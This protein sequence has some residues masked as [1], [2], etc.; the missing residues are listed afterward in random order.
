MELRFEQQ[1]VDLASGQHRDQRCSWLELW[2]P[3][4]RGVCRVVFSLLDACAFAVQSTTTTPGA[5]SY[6]GFAFDS[7]NN[8][9]W[10]F[11]GSGYSGGNV[12]CLLLLFADVVNACHRAFALQLHPVILSFLSVSVE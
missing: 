1:A 3:R 8:R 6:H 2:Q 5:R 12:A 4:R 11:A 7:T 9:L 10:L